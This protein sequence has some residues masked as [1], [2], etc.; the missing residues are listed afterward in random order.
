M[1]INKMLYLEQDLVDAL[2]GEPLSP[3]VNRLLKQHIDQ[4]A[5]ENMSIPQLHAEK[6]C[7]KLEREFKAKCKEVRANANKR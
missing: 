7:N 4:D 3:L 5:L 2:K 1:K 6:A